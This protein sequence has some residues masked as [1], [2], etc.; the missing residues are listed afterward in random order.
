MSLSSVSEAEDISSQDAKSRPS[1]LH[2]H[3]RQRHDSKSNA[4]KQWKAAAM[5]T[6]KLR[7]PWADVGFDDFEE[8]RVTRH[9]YN[10]R[11][12]KWKTDEIVVKTES[13]VAIGN[14]LVR[15]VVL[16]FFAAVCSWSHARVLQNVSRY[17]TF[18]ASSRG[19]PHCLIARLLE[20]SL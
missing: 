7:D 3:R 11:K 5:M 13:K 8:E 17:A 6:R 12:C 19:A 14:G 2:Q 15:L 16:V 20:S 9:M 10:P 1:H 4:K 18:L